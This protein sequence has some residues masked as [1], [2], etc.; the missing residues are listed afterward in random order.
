MAKKIVLLSDGTGN[1]AGKVWRTNVWRVFESL[2]LKG[3]DQ[4][5]IYDD[6]VGTSSFKPLA[7]LGGVFGYGL[8]RNVINLYKFL[9]RNYADGDKIYG[10]GFSRGAFTMRVVIGLVLNQGL[11]R[12]ANEGELDSKAQAAYRAYR[13]NK[14]SPWN[15]QYPFRLF[16]IWLD[17]FSYQPCQRPIKEIEFLGLWDTVAAYGLPIDEMTRGV[18]Q[19]IWPLEPQDRKFN[20]AIKRARHA[21]SIDDERATFHPVLWNEDE[22]NTKPSGESRPADPEQLLQVWFV[23]VHSNVGGGYPDD[24]LANVSLA[25]ILAEA[26]QAGLRF[27]DFPGDDPDALVSVDSAKDKDG[28]LY[29]SRSGLGGYYRY[30]P[31]KISDF[32]DAMPY[33]KARLRDPSKAPALLPKIHESVFGRIKMGAHVYAPIGFTEDYEVVQSGDV[34]V[35]PKTFIGEAAPSTINPNNPA[36]AEGPDA[37]LSRHT[38]QQ[39]VWNAVW[40]RRA[41][42]FL[43]VFASAFLLTYPLYRDSYA[44]E[45]SRTR[46]RIVSD[47]IRL[48]GTFLPS[49]S[50]RWL[51]A[52]ARDPAWF[53]VAAGLVGF[54]TFV[55]ASLG[56]SITDRMRLIWTRYLPGANL[57]PKTIAPSGIP[58]RVVRG[59]FAAILLY[60]ACYPIF[61]E[62]EWLHW[63]RLQGALDIVVMKLTAQPVRFIIWAF[64]IF[65]FLP[66]RVIQPVRTSRPYQAALYGF[67]YG[68]APAL[69]AAGILFFAVAL[70]SHYSFNLIDSFGNV[71]T[72]SEGTEEALKEKAGQGFSKTADKKM[73]AA[74]DWDTSLEGHDALCT[75]TGVYVS[76][77]KSYRV[78]VKRLPANDQTGAGI[79]TFWDEPSYMGGQPISRLSKLKSWVM[80]ILFPLR[81]TFD[82]PWGG[83]ILRMGSTGSEEDFL[84]RPAPAQSDGL[85]ETDGVKQ[86]AISR[87]PEAL[88]EVLRPRRDGELFI[89]LNKPVLGIPGFESF[90]SDHL[91]GNSGKAHLEIE[92]LE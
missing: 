48:L 33:S 73:I 47:T 62:I 53:L 41:I 15:L 83:V 39:G 64:L 34:T 55:S 52:Y 63:L 13:H 18:N 5:A 7:I 16:R 85:A 76:A 19:W 44:F 67:K 70:A 1:S 27:K 82:R 49:I 35:N 17:S 29:D 20:P 92:R 68:L 6:G 72:P 12:F 84:D 30:S 22:T 24:S 50:S 9:C 8:K 23:G 37:A 28:R 75:P 77:G 11:V 45:E 59:I 78:S 26:K 40:R 51:D 36:V 25:W 71:C 86:Y 80:A 60:L 90:I 61:R 58:S 46:L 4:I 56:G 14:Y 32:Y 91:I 88:G 89:Y 81:R 21:L 43:T 87:T 42:Y 3:S 54:L 2:E 79:W 69:S 65:Y 74:F 10:F 66:E 38:E 31:R 57:A